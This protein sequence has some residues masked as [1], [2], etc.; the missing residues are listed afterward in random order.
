MITE[1]TLRSTLVALF[2]RAMTELPSDIL[3]ALE[4]GYEAETD[5]VPQM[6]LKTILDNIALSGESEVPM[7]QDTGLPI[8]FATMNQHFTKNLGAPLE[9]AVRAAVKEATESVP[10]RPNAVHP[11]SREN[12]GDNTGERIPIVN[13]HYTE[14][15]AQK[16]Y[17]EL[18][19]F[20]KG[21][22]S[23]NMSQLAMLTPSD[24]K[25]GIIEFV[26]D[27]MVYA[28]G[29]PCPPVILGIGIGG[30][31]DYAMKLAKEAL[32]RP[33]DHSHPD[34]ELAAL[35]AELLTAVNKLGIGP[36]G[37]GGKTTALGVNIEYAYCHT[38]SLPVGLNIQCWAARQATARIYA[39]GRV[40]YPKDEGA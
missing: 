24:G 9:V 19:V 15:P 26:L 6:Q 17:L 33:I 7:C 34:E 13:I 10:L 32:L 28:G 29:K 20:P 30:T 3:S 40:E 14:E 39:D 38:A 21:A 37:L 11:L 12:P 18:T 22:G 8:V 31:A 36:M 16:D 23:E 2:Q 25:E 4:A 1:A 35:E 5:T 27:S